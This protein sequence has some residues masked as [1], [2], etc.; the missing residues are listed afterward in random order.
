MSRKLK[1]REDGSFI[2][3]QFTD[4]HWTN[5]SEQDLKS[6]ALMREVLEKEKP[7]LVVFTG[8]T[9]VS[10]D[11]LNS[12]RK[13]LAPVNEAQIP[14]AV[15][16]GNHDDEEGESKAALLAVQ[17]ESDLCLTEA[18]DPNISGL[19]NY[20]LKISS[21]DGKKTD[22]I[23]YMFDSGTYNNNQKVEGYGFIKRDQ[24]RWYI[25]SSRSIKKH[26]GDIPALAFFHIPLP[27]YNDVWYQKTCYGEKNEP[28]CCPKQNSGLFSAMLEM[29]DVKGIFVGHDHVN[30]Y[31]GELYGIKLHYGRAT[32]YNTYGHENFARGARIIKLKEGRPEFES[33][34]RLD[35][36]TVV[37]NQAVH[38]PDPNCL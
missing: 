3:V 32:G 15:V 31:Y 19:C 8:D 23:L 24:I 14:F 33:W 30:D 36:G 38:L 1:F 11:N 22:R 28:V 35:D 25:N 2:I 12:L 4:V 16:F 21:H 37:K 9:S 10:E 6:S 34:L 5:G 18:G 29:G 13:A 20:I 27:E 7:D 26:C 17:Q